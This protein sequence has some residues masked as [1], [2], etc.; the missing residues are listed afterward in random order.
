MSGEIDAIADITTGAV[1]A[2]AVESDTGNSNNIERRVCLNCKTALHGAHCHNCGQKGNVHRTLRAFGHDILHSVLHFDGKIWRTLPL[3]FL[4]PGELTRRYIHG[5]RASFVSPIALFLFM[6]FFSFATFSWVSPSNYDVAPAK[7]ATAEEAKSVYEGSRKNLLYGIKELETSKKEAIAEKAPEG[8]YSWIDGEIA[9]QR[10]ALAKLEADGAKGFDRSVAVDRKVSI[11]KSK[12]EAEIERLEARIAE[13]KKLGKPTKDLEDQL[14]GV[15][16][17]A[18]MARNAKSILGVGK[19]ERDKVEINILGNEALE[20]AAEHA[21]ENPQLLAY[22]IQSNTYKYSWALIPISLPFMWLL[23]FWRRQFKMFDHAVFVTYSLCFMMAL[24]SIGALVIAMSDEDSA[25]FVIAIC[26]LTFLPP[27]HMYKQLRGAYQTG[28]FSSLWRTFMLSNFA[29]L[30]LT[31][32]A[33]LIFTLG[34][35]G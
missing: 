13:E 31:L 34:I 17:G 26:V 16:L 5:E 7:P 29:L 33:T 10:A 22:K 4:K 28:R 18:D 15:K 20:E 32:F 2:T 8:S 30:A 19:G 14:K 27:I 6:V 3:L 1:V 23:F 12:L 11:E 24:G 21:I 9:R 35:T 25:P